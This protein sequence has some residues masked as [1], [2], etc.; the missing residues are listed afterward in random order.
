ML[1]TQL[2]VFEGDDTLYNDRE[3]CVFLC[4]RQQV[5]RVG[6]LCELYLGLHESAQ[7]QS[8]TDCDLANLHLP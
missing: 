3:L 6:N 5:L 4:S 1:H 7:Y 8:R 2:D